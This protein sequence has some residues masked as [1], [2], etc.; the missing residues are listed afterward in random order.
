MYY[1]IKKLCEEKKISI[2]KMCNEVGVSPQSITNLKNRSV[3]NPDACLSL[4]NAKKIADFLGCSIT[5]LM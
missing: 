2:C 3:D 5:D 4:A 1:K